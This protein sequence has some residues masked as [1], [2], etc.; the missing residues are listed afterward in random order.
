MIEVNIIEQILLAK[1]GD[2]QAFSVIYEFYLTP[3]YRYIYFRTG[4]G[5]LAKDLVQ[6]TFIKIFN[7]LPNLQITDKNP[8]TYFY[9]IARNLLIDN[10]RKK[11]IPTIEEDWAQS[12]L[13][14]YDTPETEAILQEKIYELKLA[15]NQLS[16]VEADALILKYLDN[17]NNLDISKIMGKSEVAIRQ[18]QSRG[19]RKLKKIIKQD[20]Q[21]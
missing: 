8:L 20:E 7:S 15:L 19:L 11:R 6:E 16:S 1:N 2:Q 14:D 5:E 21:R 9:T 17:Q 10:Y 12:I 3:I 18:L 13:I 4:D